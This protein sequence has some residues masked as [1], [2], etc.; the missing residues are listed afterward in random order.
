MC[1]SDLINEG[2]YASRIDDPVGKF[3]PVLVSDSV[4]DGAPAADAYAKAR[5]A[6]L[7]G[8]PAAFA[9]DFDLIKFGYWG[10]PADLAK[11]QANARGY[12]DPKT[13]KRLML[14]QAPWADV[15]RFSPAE[16]GL[17]RLQEM[18]TTR[19]SSGGWSDLHPMLAL[20]NLGCDQIIYITRRGE[21]SPFA[22]GVAKDLG[23]TA[24]QQQALYALDAPPEGGQP[25]SFLQ[26]LGA[27]DG[28]WCTNWNAFETAQVAEASDDAYA[29]PFERRSERLAAEAFAAYENA[30]ESIGLRGCTPLAPP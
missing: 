20:R 10:R 17:A 14:G 5:E 15:L 28:V 4:L 2:A 16:P 29:A 27:A 25:S 7:A 9:L 19:V 1:S 22:L 12:T 24:D 6:Y 30:K 23:M 3:L 21:E 18:T 11:V 13:A 26:S 8:K